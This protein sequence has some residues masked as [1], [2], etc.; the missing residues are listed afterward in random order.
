MC[1]ILGLGSFSKANKSPVVPW[2]LGGK[3]PLE[4]GLCR[5]HNP[6]LVLDTFSKV[7]NSGKQEAKDQSPEYLEGRLQ[8]LRL[9][10]LNRLKIKQQQQKTLEELA[11]ET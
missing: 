1:G 11:R 2:C 10:R 5:K 8:W 6:G 3:I 7:G 9:R 4:D